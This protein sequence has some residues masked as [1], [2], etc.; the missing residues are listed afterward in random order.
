[1]FDRKYIFFGL[2]VLMIGIVISAGGIET[3]LEEK[4]KDIDLDITVEEKSSGFDDV[5]TEA[6]LKD[7]NYPLTYKIDCLEKT[8]IV[9]LNREGLFNN[10]QIEI[11]VEKKCLNYSTPIC[12]DSY[13]DTWTEEVCTKEDKT[14]NYCIKY[15]TEKDME[16]MCIDYYYNQGCL[17]WKTI[18]HEEEICTNFTEA[19]CLEYSVVDKDALIKQAIVKELN[20]YVEVF[21]QRNQIKTEKSDTNTISGKVI[22]K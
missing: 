11:N 9:T 10:R 22:I 7:E 3:L 1:M 17:E 2:I 8:C 6:F 4:T 19:V 18:T 5:L 12:L 14:E 20:R 15:S 16:E 13:T 21:N